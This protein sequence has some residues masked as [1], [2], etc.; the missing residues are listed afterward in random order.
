MCHQ[1]EGETRFSGNEE[2][3]DE[4]MIKWDGICHLAGS[5]DD[6]DLKKLGG[7]KEVTISE[8]SSSGQMNLAI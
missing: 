1:K 5:H 2:V 3:L 4:K 8:N 6:L 7:E